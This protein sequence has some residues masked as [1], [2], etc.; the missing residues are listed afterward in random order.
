MKETSGCAV[1]LSNT[2]P[3]NVRKRMTVNFLAGQSWKVSIQTADRSRVL[4]PE[5]P[6][7]AVAPQLPAPR[8]EHVDVPQL[9]S[10]S[11]FKSAA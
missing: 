7:S 2:V 1:Y 6:P 4:L 11:R 5:W 9:K 8:L 10:I 3:M